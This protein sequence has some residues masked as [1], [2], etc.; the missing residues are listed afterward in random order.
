MTTAIPAD[1]EKRLGQRAI[2]YL[3][4]NGATRHTA[5]SK[6]LRASPL[7]LESVM[8]DLVDAERVVRVQDG[9]WR[10]RLIHAWALKTD[11]RA[12]EIQT[13]RFSFGGEEIL[14]AFQRAAIARA[15]AQCTK[16]MGVR[17]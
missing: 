3:R 10:G 12:S 1:A 2:K 6:A 7:L 13:P 4:N 5:M 17:P 9:L 11:P 14:Q 8:S 16:A 15:G